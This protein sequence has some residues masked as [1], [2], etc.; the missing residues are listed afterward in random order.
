MDRAGEVWLGVQLEDEAD[1][2]LCVRS[3]VRRQ[4]GIA[5]GFK[6]F[7]V[8]LSTGEEF[9]KRE[10]YCGHYQL[11]GFTDVPGRRRLT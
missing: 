1:V 3:E 7:F 6:H 10:D 11:E 8:D 5:I 9:T 2:C 4:H